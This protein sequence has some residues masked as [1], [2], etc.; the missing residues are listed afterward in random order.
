ME[1]KATSPDAVHGE[2]PTTGVSGP[3]VSGLSLTKFL[4]P[5]P[6][7]PVIT[8][9]PQQEL[10]QLQITM[11]TECVTLHSQLPPT[12]VWTYNGSF[13]GPTIRVRRGQKL[14]VNWQN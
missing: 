4:D 14:R 8:V 12:T 5:M 11:R 10:S 6:I 2:T 7:P 3:G 9:P 1:I 13:P